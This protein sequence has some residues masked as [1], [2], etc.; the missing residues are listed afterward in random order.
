MS[1]WR[2]LAEKFVRDHDPSYSLAI[3]KE[4]E[5]RG[6]LERRKAGLSKRQAETL[7]FLKT[8]IDKNGFAPSLTEICAGT[9]K[10][11]RGAMWAILKALQERGYIA[12]LPNTQRSI[13]ILRD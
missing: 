6:F 7:E 12:M 13:T 2:A 4:V 9:N 5:R 8:F 3:A 10:K 1:T 11:S